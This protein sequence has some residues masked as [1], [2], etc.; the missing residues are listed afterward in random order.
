MHAN[1]REWELFD[2]ELSYNH[3]EYVQHRVA[4]IVVALGGITAAFPSYKMAGVAAVIILVLLFCAWWTYWGSGLERRRFVVEAAY[5]IA[6]VFGMSFIVVL[7]VLD[8]DWRELVRLI[9][10]L[11]IS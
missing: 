7:T 3:P 11:Y 4:A 6:L 8:F 5:R 10:E 1:L 9:S 2:P